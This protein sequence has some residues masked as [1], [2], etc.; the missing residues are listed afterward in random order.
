MSTDALTDLTSAQRALFVRLLE[1]ERRGERELPPIPV[2]GRDGPLPLSS[3]EERLWFLDR[4]Q[5]G[6]AVYTMVSA[7]RLY[8]RVDRG[9]LGDA[10]AGLVARHENLRTTFPSVG[11]QPVRVIHP[12]GTVRLEVGAASGGGAAGLQALVA[13]QVREPFDLSQGPLLRVRLV[14]E[15][16]AVAVLVVTMHHIIS[17]DWSMGI[18]VRELA[19]G[20]G[21]LVTGA[22]WPLA[23][24][25]VQPG[26]VA[27]WQRAPAQVAAQ[28]ADVAYWTGRL[29]GLT[30]LPLPGDRRRGATPGFRGGRVP[31]TVSRAVMA[32]VGRVGQQVHATPFMTVL[33][34]WQVLLSRY[35][36]VTDVAV[37]SPV[38]NRPRA[39]LEPLIGFF[40][41]TLVLRTD[42][43]GDP[44]WR[45]AVARTRAG[46][47][48][49]YA[50]QGAPFEQVVAAVQPARLLSQTP[51]F[52]VML[53]VQQTPKPPL[54]T[55]G[56]RLEAVPVGGD[57]A[58]FDLLLSLTEQPD[59][60][61]AG[62]FNYS[63]DVWSRA[64]VER[65]AAHWQRVLAAVVAAP[66]GRIGAVAL[67]GPDEQR[68]VH[69]VGTGPPGRTPGWWADWVS[70]FEAAVARHGAAVAVVGEQTLDYQALDAAAN[71][72]AQWLLAQGVGAEQVVAVAL[73]RSTAWV[74]AVIGIWKAGAVA[75][76]LDLAAGAARRTA[77]WA[78]LGPAAVIARPGAAV[79]AGVPVLRLA[80]HDPLPTGARPIGARLRPDQLAY[81]L[82]TS[83]SSV[84][85]CTHRT[86]AR[87]ASWLQDRRPLSHGDVLLTV[88]DS[89]GDVASAA[90]LWP[91]LSGAAVV[92]ARDEDDDTFEVARAAPTS[93]LLTNEYELAELAV[94]PGVLERMRPT[95]IVCLAS[96]LSVATAAAT[97]ARTGAAI[98]LCFGWPEPGEVAYARVTVPLAIDA[99]DVLR[100]R[101]LAPD[102]EVRVEDPYGNRVPFGVEGAIVC[103][104]ATP[105]SIGDRGRLWVDG[106]LELTALADNEVFWRQG[107]SNLTALAARLQ[108]EPDVEEA[109][110]LRR[111]DRGGRLHLVAY[112]VP[113]HPV[114]G[115]GSG[116]AVTADLE[117]ADTLGHRLAGDYAAA[118]LPSAVVLVDTVP[119]DA[120]GTVHAAALE[121]LPVVDRDAV[122]RVERAAREASGATEI[123]VRWQRPPVPRLH[124]SDIV[125]ATAPRTLDEGVPPADVPPPSARDVLAVAHG[126]SVESR[127][128]RPETLRDALVHAAGLAT[129]QIVYVEGTAEQ[130]VESYAGLLDRAECI[131][132]GLRG[133]GLAPGAPVLL[134]LSR[135][136]D[137]LGALWG[138]AL[139]GFRPV[140]I[141]PAP[142]DGDVLGER[143][144]ACWRALGHPLIVTSLRDAAAPTWPTE[145]SC[146]S[147]RAGEPAP[148]VCLVDRL[149]AHPPDRRHHQGG[150]DDPAVLMLTSGTTGEPKLI[151]LSHRNLLARARAANDL[152][153]FTSA[154][155]IVSW[156]PLH[157]SGSLADWHVRAVELGCS[158]VYA[159]ADDVAG[160]PR[161]WL[162]LLDR[163]RASASWAPSF[164]YQLV[165]NEVRDKG[166]RAW[167]LSCVE[168]LLTA[169]ESVSRRAIVDF[170]AALTQYGLRANCIRPAYG[171]TELASGVTYVRPGSE[172]LR[173][174]TIDRGRLEGRI[175]RT[176]D[177]APNSLA[178]A[179][180]GAPIAGMSLR[181]VDGDG[182]VM[183]EETI[184][185][186]QVRGTA[187]SPGRYG[188]AA[189]DPE[190]W[191]ETGDR[192]FLCEG[193]LVLTGRAKDIV[194]V[195]GLNVDCHEIEQAVEAVD[196]VV[197]SFTAACQVRD[198][199]TGLEQVAVFFHASIADDTPG[200][201]RRIRGALAAH[202]G[203][204]PDYLVP[205]DQ[206]EIPKT[207]TG[208]IRRAELAQRFDRRGFDARLEAADMIEST[209]RTVPA[210]FFRRCGRRADVGASPDIADGSA[211]DRRPPTPTLSR[212]DLRRELAMNEAIRPG[213]LYVIAG[214]PGELGV[215]T[216]EW[217]LTHDGV[218]VL[219]V[220]GAAVEAGDHA[221]QFSQLLRRTDAARYCT[222]DDAS[223][224]HGWLDVMRE[225]ARA[226]GRPIDGVFD[227]GGV[228][229]D[230]SLAVLDS[231][232][233][234]GNP[235]LFVT[236]S[237]WRV[238]VG[239]T[240][241]AAALLA[242]HP[243]A[244]TPPHDPRRRAY[245]ITWASPPAAFGGQAATAEGSRVE[246]CLPISHRQALA[247]LRAVLAR[248][249]GEWLIGLDAMHPRIARTTVDLPASTR[250]LAAYCAAADGGRP[251][252]ADIELTDAFGTA[253]R[254][255]I[256]RL[257]ARA[258]LEGVGENDPAALAEAARSMPAGP[259]GDLERTLQRIWE[260]VLQRDSVGLDE[261]FFDLGGHSLLI[262]K[263]VDQ[264]AAAL[265]RPLP[266]VDVFHYP[267]VR[268]LA[269]RLAGDQPVAEPPIADR[270]ALARARRERR[271]QQG[272]AVTG[273]P[274]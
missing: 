11:G 44:T 99:L 229:G 168:Y 273:E 184:G 205:V 175:R 107:R 86:I 248:R 21:A 19:A 34:A 197:P 119:R 68:Q 128:R 50:H 195:N 56:V 101:C 218:K 137:L 154:Q 219:I 163:Y 267:T 158:A 117:L 17:D 15:G 116:S 226:W 130:H 240:G 185:R 73:E 39:E 108:Q 153:G 125:G 223:G 16:P 141:P 142:G 61:W 179:D 58:P 26:D 120:N 87:R 196:G 98:H 35:S 182:T 222:C 187:V 212:V 25:T 9:A 122:Q 221:R 30:P 60:R 237:S 266:V 32:G 118:D 104:G 88:S 10:V 42:L 83:G 28:A 51:L 18:L 214:E 49:A 132:A 78:G 203:L 22:A 146:A 156:L 93:V 147:G 204:T 210:W 84:A 145:A 161:S 48:E 272:V 159:R 59:G 55:G 143:V 255:R 160:D 133:A 134:R 69:G 274:T 260:S 47:V 258:L 6:R 127:R 91:L 264:V 124:V 113:R 225:A 131:L 169:G 198:A 246:G 77:V 41:N 53:A 70:R 201:M 92:F 115:A 250:W 269:G 67:V 13:A 3:G 207:S 129:G 94:R 4:L 31:V 231:S 202:T 36:G 23:P 242:L 5:A 57:A 206:E 247:S 37:G 215:L 189:R 209:E 190:A 29:A 233:T 54:A 170:T 180:L 1:R 208:K 186:L 33:A 151:V 253:F 243:P 43:S 27:C 213:G 46:C 199:A 235:E 238:P 148:I 261:N 66:G 256:N 162:D 7:T 12:V 183:L 265:G 109:V 136:S 111:R 254:C 74:A 40:V 271:A 97:H 75:A 14:V 177:R 24:L 95:D 224:R 110:V 20:Y 138:C 139:G 234:S 106:T 194:I 216:A 38:T 192:A 79:P 157:H 152:C 251:L 173:F 2:V 114:H 230:R 220:V 102:V 167:D 257:D 165:A 239:F 126:A 149:A 52:Q 64:A 135:N 140:P 62:M 236:L 268:A 82:H 174:H 259:R 245:D 85:R 144:L 188:V 249:P 65:L 228:A 191:F 200:V 193:R 80:P 270:K 112:I 63:D 262:L 252:P 150:A 164:A 211:T 176:P 8:G 72:V 89:S 227:F 103:G 100:P 105:A 244:M 166:G 155:R 263:M 76:P 181:I 45:E 90:V 217:L 96:E 241:D 71:G 172:P 123:L 232:W 121:S 178:F 81:L 171:M